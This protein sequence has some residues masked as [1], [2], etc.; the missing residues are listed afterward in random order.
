M[1]TGITDRQTNLCD[2]EVGQVVADIF[3]QASHGVSELHE[4]LIDERGERVGEM[5][6]SVDG[7]QPVLCDRGEQLLLT[8]GQSS[9]LQLQSLRAR[10]HSWLQAHIG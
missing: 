2:F 10:A 7:G 3:H 1:T 5:L 4:F 9:Y 6:A 8:G